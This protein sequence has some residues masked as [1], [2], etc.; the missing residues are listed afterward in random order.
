MKTRMIILTLGSTV[1][2]NSTGETRA[3]SPASPSPALPKTMDKDES[4]TLKPGEVHEVTLQSRGAA[5]LQ[6]LYRTSTD[7]VVEVKRKDVS[8]GDAKQIPPNIGGAIP[9]IF[10]IKALKPGDTRV[11][12]Y[13]T[14]PWDKSFK[15]IIGK[16]ISIKVTADGR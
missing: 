10:T 7:S 4:I 11:T 15:E 8:P 13:E 3:Q 5:G 9:V 1:F 14:R 2:W 12:F 16:K 6:L